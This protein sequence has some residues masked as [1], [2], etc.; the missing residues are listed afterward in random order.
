MLCRARFTRLAHGWNRSRVRPS[1]GWD[2]SQVAG[3]IGRG[4]TFNEGFDSRVPSPARGDRSRVAAEFR[5]SG[6]RVVE[7][8]GG[9]GRGSCRKLL[10][11][12]E[13]VHKSAYSWPCFEVRQGDWVA[14]CF[15]YVV[16]TKEKSGELPHPYPFTLVFILQNLSLVG[17]ATPA[18]MTLQAAAKTQRGQLP[19]LTLRAGLLRFASSHLRSLAPSGRHPSLASTRLPLA[20]F[21]RGT[22]Y[23]GSPDQVGSPSPKSWPLRG[24]IA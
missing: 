15:F 7:I 21:G 1:I 4:T 6:S 2:G 9:M 16:D 3:G 18:P 14:G 20:A 23:G 19:S 11:A 13:T 5:G 24:D 12:A 10:E 17:T 8:A 22:P